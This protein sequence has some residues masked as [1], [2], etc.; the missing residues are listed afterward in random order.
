MSSSPGHFSRA[1]NA[2]AS[3]TK[4]KSIYHYQT[5]GDILASTPFGLRI[6]KFYWFTGS[7]CAATFLD[8]TSRTTHTRANA[9]HLIQ[10]MSI[11]I[12][13]QAISLLYS[14]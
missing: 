11:Y 5:P 6:A 2:D 3:V 10:F 7:K 14:V 12:F 8:I 1:L 13:L 4:H 9:S